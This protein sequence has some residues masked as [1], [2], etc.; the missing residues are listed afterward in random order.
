MLF[1]LFG[2]APPPAWVVSETQELARLSEDELASLTEQCLRDLVRRGAGSRRER[3]GP[4][5]YATLRFLLKSA[6]QFRNAPE[7][8]LLELQQLGLP[9]S[10]AQLITARYAARQHELREALSLQVL[11]M[12]ST[13]AEP[14]DVVANLAMTDAQLELLIHE[15]HAARDMMARPQ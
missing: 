7:D 10:H 13:H 5:Q 2:Q 4:H 3:E 8:A 12:S 14:H 15:L 11:R 1:R 6:A 9:L